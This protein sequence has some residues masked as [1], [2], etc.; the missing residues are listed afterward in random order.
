MGWLKDFFGGI[1]LGDVGNIAMGITQAVQSRKQRESNEQLVRETNAN[2]RAMQ[3]SANAT[4]IQLQESANAAQAAESEK[5]YQRSKAGNQVNLMQ[6]AGMSKAGAIN[7]LNGGG[8]Y[9]PATVNAGQVSASQDQAPQGS[10]IDFSGI[11]QAFASMSANEAQMRNTTKQIKAQSET[12]DKAIKSQ[13]RIEKLKLEME[14]RRQTME[15]FWKSKEEKRRQHDHDLAFLNNEMRNAAS[16]VERL[17]DPAQYDTPSAYRAALYDKATEEQRKFFDNHEFTNVL[18]LYHAANASAKNVAANTA[19]TLSATQIAERAAKISESLG[20]L[21]IKEK[22]IDIALKD[23]EYEQKSELLKFSKEE[24]QHKTEMW[25]YE[26]SKAK[27]D[28]DVARIRADIERECKQSNIDITIAHN[29]LQALKDSM[30]YGVLL[31]GT[32]PG[33]RFSDS[34]FIGGL[35]FLFN[36]IGLPIK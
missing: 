2:N 33:N 13:E 29:Q 14:E 12:Q 10:P 32:Q 31:P 16:A 36:E 27:S 5:A 11:L 35:W 25:I 15:D 24:M 3:E 1:G 6:Q 30:S 21:S 28:A 8:S 4:N 20:K 34:A 26:L 19:H 22:S 17:A 18:D 23:L 9:T 7:A